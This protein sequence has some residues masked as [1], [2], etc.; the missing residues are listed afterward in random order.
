MKK[1]ITLAVDNPVCVNLIMVSLLVMGTVIY[2]QVMPKEIF[3][4]FSK[5]QVLITTFYAGASAEEVEANITL[6]IEDVIRD[7]DDVQE[8]VSTS[9]EGQS[10]IRIEAPQDLKDMSGLINDIRQ[11]IDRIDDFPPEAEDPVVQEL[12][13]NYPVITVSLYGNINLLSLKEMVEDLK[14]DISALPGVAEARITGLPDREVWVE[15]R[16]GGLKEY[17]ITLTDIT[18][19]LQEQHF[20]LPAGTMP[21]PDGEFL[22]RI[23]GRKTRAQD[24]ISLV[25]KTTP[26]GGQV[27]LGDVA[28]IRDWFEREQNIGRYNGHRAINLNVTKTRSGDAIRLVGAIRD[29]IQEYQTLLPAGVRIGVFN[30]LSVYIKNRLD[31]L[32]TNGL[33]GLVIVFILLLI[34]LNLRTSLFVTLG[35]PVSFLG[36]IILMHLFGMT[37]NMIAM[38]ALIVVLGMVVDDAVVVGENVHWYQEQ[39]ASPRDAAVQGASEVA[40]PVLSAVATTLA[41]FFPITLI[42]GQMGDFLGVIPLVVTF[43]LLVSLF[44]SL[45]ILPSHLA[46]FSSPAPPPPCLVRRQCRAMIGWLTVRYVGILTRV[47]AWRYVFVTAAASFSVLLIL[48]AAFYLPFVLFGQFEGSQFFVNMELPTKNS[49]KQSEFFLTGVEKRI[50]Q[51]VPEDELVS[52]VCN[53]GNIMDDFDNIRI[54]NHLSQCVVELKELDKGRTRELAAVMKD[55]RRVLTPLTGHAVIQLKEI[56]AGPGGAPIHLQVT[57]R[58]MKVLRDLAREITAFVRTI[59]GT[60]DV[61]DSLESGKPELQIR[62]RPEGRLLGLSEQSLARELRGV[63]WGISGPSYQ[64]ETEDVDIMIKFPET[65]RERYQTLTDLLVPLPDGRKVPLR[66]VAR[67]VKGQGISRIMRDNGRRAVVITGEL[68][69]SVT[70][71]DTVSRAVV[72]RFKNL[73]RTHPGYELATEKGEVKELRD[74][75]G[76]LKT[77]FL[78][79]LLIIY[80]ILG[81]QFKSY[82]QPLVV[83]SAIPF[84]IDGVLLGHL[85]L[86]KSLSI[87]SMIGLVALSGIVVND[88][89]VLV[90]LVNRLR[91]RGADRISALM[92][93]GKQRFRPVVLTSLTTM[94]GVFFL[95]FLARGQARFLSPM[96]VSIFFGL[97][98][99]TV[100]T[101]LIVPCLYAFLED[102]KKFFRRL[103]E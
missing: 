36:A 46:D 88:S 72:E 15:V 78:M 77:G 9:Q 71:A 55:V 33:Q 19:M 39:G 47:L 10:F 7:V 95:A 60:T 12:E 102:G 90:D 94:G 89:L 1:L 28:V 103:R 14:D 83:M 68:D 101:L 25:L 59:P 38:F 87:L 91:A 8:Y 97:M 18:R 84:G 37:M 24:L 32:K 34:S 4:E 79:G 41:A 82:L 52:L 61:K 5:N 53:A 35:I 29:R 2:A 22:I 63:F 58:D 99:S 62:L 69:Q 40:L 54:G 64:T 80:F 30:D 85:M 93:A 73:G 74:S 3:P 76:S 44:E 16:P 98:V 11:Q 57:G 49:L 23:M 66:D 81:T 96:A 51:V 67:V 70:T 26:R 86:G 75:M 17:G 13:S 92:Q 43:A 21:T 42:P 56:S 20:D 65:A 27:R 100:I 48:Y 31:V 6:K 45:F 50:M